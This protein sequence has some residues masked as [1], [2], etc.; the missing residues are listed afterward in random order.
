MGEIEI[1]L[2]E[3]EEQLARLADD[4]P[5]GLRGHLERSRAEVMFVLASLADR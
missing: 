3:V 2:H 4:V 5:A 1:H